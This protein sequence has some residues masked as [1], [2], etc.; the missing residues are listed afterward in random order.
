MRSTSRIHRSGR[1]RG[2]ELA[3]LVSMVAMIS[4]LMVAAPGF[5]SV[6]DDEDGYVQWDTA[7]VTEA[8]A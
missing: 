6:E 3:V 4:T 1:K 8:A 2:R 5:A 7:S